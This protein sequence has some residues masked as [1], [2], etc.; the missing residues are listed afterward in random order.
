MIVKSQ[1][2]AHFDQLVEAK[3]ASD[4][5]HHLN[6]LMNLLRSVLY[7]V[8]ARDKVKDDGIESVVK[9]LPSVF[10]RDLIKQQ[11]RFSQFF[12]HAAVIQVFSTD[13]VA[14]KNTFIL[15][16][17]SEMKQ[18]VSLKRSDQPL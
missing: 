2:F 8:K 10:L 9:Y 18:T 13:E 7:S 14:K 17:L 15:E 6:Q 4:K 11:P 16:L 12:S 1:V 5:T 3:S